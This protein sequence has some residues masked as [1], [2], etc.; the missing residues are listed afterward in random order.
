[1]TFSFIW[2]APRKLHT[3]SKEKLEKYYYENKALKC[4]LFEDLTDKNIAENEILFLNW[5]SINKDD[6]IIIRDNENDF[7]LSNILQNTR[8]QG[9]Q[10]ILIIDESH[11]ST[12]T[13]IANGLREMISPKLTMEMSATPVFS[14]AELVPVDREDVIQDEMI[15]KY[16]VINPDLKNE[17]I[18]KFGD[19]IFVKSQDT[20][21]ELLLSE[22][23][24]KREQLAKI[25][26]DLKA[27]VNPLLLIQLPDKSV[28]AD[29][30]KD[31]IV[32]ILKNKHNITV[33]NGRLAIYLSEDKKNLETITKI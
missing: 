20:T 9:R 7:N 33:E 3:Q 5:E 26:S 19:E 17:I 29:D 16:V 24:K 12:D 30:H 25:L 28:T 8:D 31:E 15:K 6:N 32:S 18:N 27:H 13:K 21:N 4:S 14:G 1:L 10:I 2:A 11:F 22:A 23:L